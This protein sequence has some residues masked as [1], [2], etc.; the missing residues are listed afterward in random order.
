MSC[1]NCKKLRKRIKKLKKELEFFTESEIKGRSLLLDIRMRTND[2]HT[3][4]IRAIEE[5]KK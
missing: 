3:W 2:Y 4:L 1:E 5:V